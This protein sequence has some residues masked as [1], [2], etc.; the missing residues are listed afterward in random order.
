[1]SISS[2]TWSAL[3][4]GGNQH[5]RVQLWLHG[6]RQHIHGFV[7]NSTIFDRRG[8]VGVNVHHVES[9][10]SDFSGHLFLRADPFW[11]VFRVQFVYRCVV[12]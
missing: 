11:G 5:R 7:F 12:R 1:M 9:L 4:Q 6:L 3:G 8:L 10:L 2:T